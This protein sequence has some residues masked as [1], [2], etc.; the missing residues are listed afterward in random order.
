M[1]PSDDVTHASAD[2]TGGLAPTSNGPGRLR[3]ADAPPV[4]G[5]FW[6]ASGVV[7]LVL[8]AVVIVVSLLSAANDNARINRLRT[9]GVAVSVT[10]SNCI[11]NLGGSGSNAANYTCQGHYRV[12]ATNYDETI[13]G[14]TSFVA[15]G[16]HV[17]AVADPSNPS[18]IT[19]ASA[20]AS[21]RA[22]T[23][24]F[25]VPGL[26]GLVWFV[27][28]VAYVRRWRR[29]RGPRSDAG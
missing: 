19:L 9:S 13:D 27:V 3:G 23:A 8:L 6:A 10:V 26:L 2:L 14:L 18:S 24:R 11:G 7:V 17:A 15:T 5:R 25:V 20:V 22:S 21:S 16:R 29:P 12:G 1:T 4:A 28:T